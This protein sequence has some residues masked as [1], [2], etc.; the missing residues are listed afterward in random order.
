MA[1]TTGTTLTND[2]IVTC[3]V[4]QRDIELPSSRKGKERVCFLPDRL[5]R[6]QDSVIVEEEEEGKITDKW[7]SIRLYLWPSCL[8]PLACRDITNIFCFIILDLG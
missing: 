6:K 2:V 1:V 3:T 5:D 8:S 7:L 4:A